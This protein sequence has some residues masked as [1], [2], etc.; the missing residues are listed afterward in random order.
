MEIS[1]E[2]RVGNLGPR[3][4]STR[5]ALPFAVVVGTE[6]AIRCPASPGNSLNEHLV[7]LWGLLR[8]KRR[9]LKSLQ[10]NGVTLAC[11]HQAPPGEIVLLPNAA[12]FLHLTNT[13]LVIRTIGT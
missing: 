6:V 1:T 2:F 9:F 7:W 3:T 12:E 10:S 11:H 5:E 4:S 8:G 13:S